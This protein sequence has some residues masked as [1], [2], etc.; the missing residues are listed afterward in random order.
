MRVTATAIFLAALVQPLLAVKEH[1]FKKCHQSGF[2][3]RGRALSERATTAGKSWNSPYS[4]DSSSISFSS[5]HAAF[6]APVKSALYP[7]IRFELKVSILKDGVARIQMDEVN[8]LRKR[9]NEATQWALI[10]EPELKDAA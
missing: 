9:Y 3:K 4:I 7:D 5:S 2:C 1:D 10:A 8:G 6:T